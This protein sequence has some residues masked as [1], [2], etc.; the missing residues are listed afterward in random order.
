MGAADA[1]LVFGVETRSLDEMVAIASEA[2]PRTKNR[3]STEP[4]K[5]NHPP[6]PDVFMVSMEGPRAATKGHQR[7]GNRRNF[8]RVVFEVGPGT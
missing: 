7:P 2:M 8:R 1:P 4:G 3:V 6:W 5:L